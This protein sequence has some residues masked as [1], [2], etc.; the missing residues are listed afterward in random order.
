M[1]AG[2]IFEGGCLCGA[3]RYRSTAGPLRC[4]ICHC[5]YC[6][7]HSGAPILSFVH[8]PLDA[9]TWLTGE[10]RRYRSSRY[11]ERG[12]CASCGSTLSMHEEE[13]ADRVQVTLGSLDQP[14]RVKPQ[15]HVW[16]RSRI[17]WFQVAEELPRFERN[18]TAVAAS[19]VLRR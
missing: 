14:E 3:V 8:F 10:P 2:E 11:A 18:S 13:L 12:F 4:M 7:R 15:D 9:F 19:T 17:P 1:S 6:R 5:E 16:V